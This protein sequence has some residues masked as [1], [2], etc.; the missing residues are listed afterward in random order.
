MADFTF[1]LV[2]S[3]ISYSQQ[4]CPELG[5]I[6]AIDASIHTCGV[7]MAPAR[8]GMLESALRP[9]VIAGPVRCPWCVW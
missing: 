6:S 8:L 2:I 4:M 7:T 3:L 5:N 9:A 1:C